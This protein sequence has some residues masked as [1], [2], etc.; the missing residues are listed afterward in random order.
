ML[1]AQ[2]VERGDSLIT[3]E[4]VKPSGVSPSE[5]APGWDTTARLARSWPMSA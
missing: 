3:N 1:S 4:H 2:L 5:T